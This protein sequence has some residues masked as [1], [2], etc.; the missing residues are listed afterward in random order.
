M[1]LKTSTASLGQGLMALSRAEIETWTM[2]RVEGGIRGAWV[3]T[4]KPVS[5]V[6]AW[7]SR[8]VF[9]DIDM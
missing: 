4:M 2:G 1:G 7:T 8:E 5:I 9:R 3:Q 6:R